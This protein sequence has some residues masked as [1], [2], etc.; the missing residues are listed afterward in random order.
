MNPR[1]LIPLFF[2][3]GNLACGSVSIIF[4]WNHHLETAA[5]LLIIS[6]LFDGIDGWAARKLGVDGK[7]GAAVDTVAD[8]ISFALAPAFIIY[9]SFDSSIG[10]VAGA[11][12]LLSILFRLFRYHKQKMPHGMFLGMAAPAAA[13]PVAMTAALYAHG[14]LPQ[15]G[16]LLATFIF[17]LLAISTIHY[18]SWY[19]PALRFYQSDQ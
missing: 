6:A 2:T 9:R 19:S 1:V 16:I 13:L 10:L 5:M 12:Y 11:F 4:A 14:N 15:S 7:L 8:N 3:I 17:G 18:P